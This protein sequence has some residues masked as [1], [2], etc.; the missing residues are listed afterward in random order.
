LKR[1]A[2]ESDAAE[3]TTVRVNAIVEKLIFVNPDFMQNNLVIVKPGTADAIGN[4]P[5]IKSGTQLILIAFDGKK[6]TP[7]PSP[8]PNQIS[9]SQNQLS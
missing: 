3:L 9:N 1:E 7:K 6:S 2:I 5:N 4:I 8:Q